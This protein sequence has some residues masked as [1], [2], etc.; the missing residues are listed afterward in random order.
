MDDG[1]DT[2]ARRPPASLNPNTPPMLPK[3]EAGRDVSFYI[4]K[5]DGNEL[6]CTMI[7]AAGPKDRSSMIRVDKGGFVV[8]T[9]KP[10]IIVTHGNQSW[11]NQMLIGALSMKLS[12]EMDCHT[13]R[14]DFTGNGHSNGP[15]KY[16][17]IVGEGT[18]LQEV[19]R[20][21][22]EEMKCKVLCVF[23]HSKGSHAV[24]QLAVKEE[25]RTTSDRI[26]YFVISAARYRHAGVV[27]AEESLTPAQEEELNREGKVTLRHPMGQDFLITLDDWK[28]CRDLDSTF[29]SK[30]KR[31]KFLVLH[32]NKD[33]AV[34][35]E[36][37]NLYKDMLPN[38]KTV[39]IDGADHNFSGLRFMG[40]IVGLVQELVKS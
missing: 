33:Q 7:R 6:A 1:D 8:D 3:L 32:G 35:W 37:A 24:L 38:N 39:I 4:D 13:I 20:Y 15:W 22:R 19:V 16:A 31:G 23:G 17:N 10:V 25:E 5:K 30:A 21:V 40:K 9:S 36:D 11:R 14:F 18:D 2:D 12:D 26:G 27:A 29:C 28:E 34:P